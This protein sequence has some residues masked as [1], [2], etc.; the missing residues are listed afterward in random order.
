MPGPKAP[1]VPGPVF[2]SPPGSIKVIVTGPVEVKS[3]D[4]RVKIVKGG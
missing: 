3:S 4:P 2:T 1:P